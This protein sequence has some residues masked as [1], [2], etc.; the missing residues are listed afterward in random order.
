[1]VTKNKSSPVGR[2]VGGE[3]LGGYKKIGYLGGR[4]PVGWTGEL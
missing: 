4:E 1:M 3:D 2:K